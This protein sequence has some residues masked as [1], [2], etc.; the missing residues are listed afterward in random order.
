MAKKSAIIGEFVL[1]INDNDS[2]AVNLIP[3]STRKELKEIAKQ[4]KITYDD[5]LTTHQLGAL[6]FKELG[7]PGENTLSIGEYEIEKE[8]GGRINVL[9]TYSNTK[10]GLRI[11]AEKAGFDKDDKK[12]GWNTQ[13]FGRKLMSFIEN[14]S[15]IDH[16]QKDKEKK[17]DSKEGVAVPEELIGKPLVYIEMEEVKNNPPSGYKDETDYLNSYFSEPGIALAYINEGD[18]TKLMAD[19]YSTPAELHHYLVNDV[20]NYIKKQYIA[21]DD[22]SKLP[23]DY[24]QSKV[25]VSTGF[26]YKSN[27]ETIGAGLNQFYTVKK[28]LWYYPEEK[29]NGLIFCVKHGE[30]Y[31]FFDI[32][33]DLTMNLLEIDKAQFDRLVEIKK[34]G[35]G[36]EKVRIKIEEST[37][38]SSHELSNDEFKDLPIVDVK[39][40]DVSKWPE[41]KIDTDF[42][43]P[44]AVILERE[45]WDGNIE[46]E[47]WANEYSICD[48][49]NDDDII[50]WM[51][52]GCSVKKFVGPVSW[53][54]VPEEYKQGGGEYEDDFY[55]NIAIGL[56]QYVGGNNM[57]TWDLETGALFRVQWPDRTD[58]FLI[59]KEG[60]LDKKVDMSDQEFDSLIK[61][62]EK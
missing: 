23:I 20:Q 53:F 35:T 39:L 3:D 24:M 60:R 59:D 8:K 33:D 44:G 58:Y 50:P 40:T 19:D 61:K 16:P 2:V 6:I 47:A 13:Q 32:W 49:L 30:D 17:S 1:T 52:D 4:N 18:S 15:S 43:I 11:I 48:V 29:L 41:E 7:K 42:N 54:G 10:E 51:E 14:G 45:D 46:K 55:Y 25:I 31:S 9:K 5:K 36:K 56:S 57:S 38:A 26:D 22:P 28:P 21:L 34:E 37:M 12:E 27:M 62:T